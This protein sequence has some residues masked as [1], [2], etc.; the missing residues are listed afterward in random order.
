VVGAHA[1]RRLG[2]HGRDAGRDG[3]AAR[4]GAALSLLEPRLRRAGRGRGAGARSSWFDALR[5][6]LLEPLELRRTTYRPV[7]PHAVGLAVHPWAEAVL[8]EPEHD[9][10]L[11][12]AAGQ[13]W[14]TLTDL[15]RLA[16]FLLGDTGEVLSPDT[17]AEMGQSSLLDET[18]DGW[19]SYGLGLQVLNAGGHRLVGHSGAMPGFVSSAFVDGRAGVGAIWAA[20]TT[21]GGDRALLTDLL[22]IVRDCEPRVVDE[23][24]P[25]ALPPGV[26]FDGLGPYYWGPNAYALRARADGLLSLDPL[27]GKGRGSRF[28]L[29]GGT[30]TGIDGYF[31]G[32]RLE[33]GDGYVAVATFVF[34]REPYGDGPIPG[35]VDA[36]GWQT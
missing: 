12:A 26:G 25:V 34:T 14:S 1:G 2:R 9:A 22:S 29:D 30:W 33:L 10:G 23:W 4:A 31:A 17:L 16:R 5:A 35:G 20:N 7:A 28:R 8:E 11:L 36:R 21:Y 27:G 18:P 19:M 13:L 32:E 6:E 15:A 24:A 3:R